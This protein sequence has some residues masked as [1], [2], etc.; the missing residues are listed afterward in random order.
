MIVIFDEPVPLA[1]KAN[2]FI[3]VGAKQGY[4][5]LSG[6]I[7]W[8]M[9]LYFNNIAVNSTGGSGA[10]TDNV[11]LFGVVQDWS[12]G[13]YNVRVEWTGDTRIVLQSPVL[14]VQV[15]YK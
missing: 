2:L 9:T 4:S 3:T 10:Y 13:T 12:A 14:A 6:S 8:S 5:N 1:S 15:Q 11:S 7:P